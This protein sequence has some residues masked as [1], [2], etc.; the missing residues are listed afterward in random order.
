MMFIQAL[1]TLA[2]ALSGCN[3]I[4]INSASEITERKADA[5]SFTAFGSVSAVQLTTGDTRIYHQKPDGSIW[6]VAVSGVFFQGKFASDGMIVPAGEAL[7]GTPIA[8]TVN[9]NYADVHLFFLSPNLIVSEYMWTGTA[10]IGAANC[11]QCIT[12]I[13]FLAAT[14]QFLYAMENSVAG[15]PAK[16]RVG[17]NSA[18]TPGGLTEAAQVNGAW[19]LSILT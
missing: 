14:S 10:W 9:G 19:Q 1:I 17:F 12:G 2:L 6:Q 3:V 4:A 5:I 11:P 16:L 8:A 15:T 18:G 13:G 7:L